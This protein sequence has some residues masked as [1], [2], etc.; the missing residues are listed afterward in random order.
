MTEG[1]VRKEGTIPY[2]K[3]GLQKAVRGASLFPGTTVSRE[4]TRITPSANKDQVKEEQLVLT[5]LLADRTRFLSLSSSQMRAYQDPYVEIDGVTYR[6]ESHSFDLRLRTTI[7]GLD[8][9]LHIPRFSYSRNDDDTSPP[10]HQI[11]NNE[12]HMEPNTSFD[13]AIARQGLLLATQ[14]ASQYPETYIQ[15][16]LRQNACI[17]NDEAI[18]EASLE[19]F[20]TAED[21]FDFDNSRRSELELIKLLIGEKSCLLP[22][23]QISESKI[24]FR[25]VETD[26]P[27]LN[28][29]FRVQLDMSQFGKPG[30][31]NYKFSHTLLNYLPV[32]IKRVSH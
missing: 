31:K 4:F 23:G 5:A 15:Y 27:G 13:P 9:Y 10:F 3:D 11:R 16:D 26:I 17:L 29:C 1:P 21:F 30:E 19:T 14:G 8:Y 20:L 7:D 32:A 12:S 25:K 18:D 2:I 24:F 6:D 28:Y 22:F